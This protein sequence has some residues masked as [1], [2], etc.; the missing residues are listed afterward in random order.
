MARPRK[1][2]APAEVTSQ[3]GELF[4]DLPAFSRDVMGLDP[5]WQQEQLYALVMEMVNA[6]IKKWQQLPLTGREEELNSKFGIS[7]RSGMGTGKDAAVAVIVTWA[8]VN[9]PNFKGMATAPTEHQLRDV[10]WSELAKWQNLAKEKGNRMLGDLILQADRLYI[11]GS[12]MDWFFTYK[13]AAVKADSTTQASTLRGMHA[14][15]MLIVINEASGVPDPVFQPL[16]GT[17][18]GPM[19][20]VIMIS[21]MSD[22]KGYFYDSHFNA[23]AL[24]FWETLHWNSEDCPLPGMRDQVKR[25]EEKYGRDSDYYQVF[26][27]G[28]PPSGDPEVL[29]PLQWIINATRNGIEFAASDPLLIGA[30]PGRGR[31]PAVMLSRRGNVVLSPILE[32]RS[33]DTMALTGWL[34]RAIIDEKPFYV[35]VDVIG[36]GAGVYDRLRELGYTCVHPVNV[37]ELPAREDRYWRLRDELWYKVRGKFESCTISIPDD[38][39]LIGELNGIRSKP[40]TSDGLLRVES[41][42]DMRSRGLPSPNRADAL[43]ITEH[44]QWTNAARGRILE[45]EDEDEALD[46]RLEK[47]KRRAQLMEDSF[48]SV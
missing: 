7:V 38:P 27:L 26:V 21:Q 41:K 32:D 40:P 13:T 8:M 48:M 11:K 42:D 18:T 16:E 36:L 47:I 20:F 33:K 25:M 17:L 5:T 46:R 14:D 34:S 19:N 44:A 3:F 15:F 22:T 1:I 28:N 35:G 2:A 43:C 23:Q 45:E 24:R 4:W 10:S 29:I 30:D 12:K 6:R 31:D 39:I 9:F 37:A